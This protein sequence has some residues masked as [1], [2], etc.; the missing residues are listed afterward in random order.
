MEDKI[1]LSFVLLAII[2]ICDAK[3][4]ED[5]RTSVLQSISFKDEKGLLEDSKSLVFKDLLTKDGEN[6][7]L[8]EFKMSVFKD[9]LSIDKKLWL[10]DFETSVINRLSTGDLVKFASFVARLD[11]RALYEELFMKNF[12]RSALYEELCTEV[13]NTACVDC[14]AFDNEG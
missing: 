13:W 5:C 10:E 7:L 6:W 9:L 2:V 4:L 14:V 1:A 12:V 11:T 3:L 8:E